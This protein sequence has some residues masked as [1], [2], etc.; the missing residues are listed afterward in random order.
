[1]SILLE[2]NEAAMQALYLFL[3]FLPLAGF[4]AE[5]GGK[6]YMYEIRIERHKAVPM[7]DSVTLYADVYRP[8]S[9]GRYPTLLVRTPYGLQRDGVHETMIK[10]A[11]RGYSVVVVDNRGRYESG[12]NWDPF[13]SE[14][15]DGYDAI[16]WAAKQNFSNGKVATQGGSYLG[17]VQ[18]A[19]ASQQPPSLVAMFPALAST[20]I[21]ANWITHGGAFRLSFNYGW[22]VVRMPNRIML[23]Q[24]W[25]TEAYTP[26]ELKYENI[27]WHLPLNTGDLKSAGSEVKHYRDWLAHPS[28]DSYWKAISDEER[29]NKMQVPAEVSGG[30]FDIFLAGTINGYTMMK[31]QAATERARKNTRMIIGPWGHGPTQKYGDVDF[32]KDAMINQ[33]DEELAFFDHNLKGLDNGLDRNLPVKIFYMGVNKWRS[34]KD[35]PIPDTN[36]RELYLG[37]AGAANSV[38]GGGTLSF[39]KPAATQIHQYNYNPEEPVLTMGGN[40]C[41][42]TPTPAGPKDQRHIEGRNDVLVYTSEFLKTPISIAGPVKMKLTAATDGPDTDWMVKLVDVYPNGF[43]MPVAEGILRARFRN[44]LDKP[45]LLTPNTVYDFTVDLVGTA[46][47]FQPGHRIRVD[48]TSSNFPQFDRN[49]NTGEALGAGTRTRVAR[50]SVHTGGPRPSHIVLPVVTQP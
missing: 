3:L 24:Y 13:R 1:M 43:A 41:C 46:N 6:P 29:M 22:G 32:G 34:E 23:P 4:A 25:H 28:Y 47:V 21:Y 16:E 7:R 15:Q 48:I 2:S 42:G 38:R 11:Q 17:H 39:D 5:P 27:L 33:F 26:E 30:W 19:A 31:Q 20:N 36:Y 14:A 8:S 12:G 10:F 18:W 50:Q 40:N 49:P 37:G 45:E 44:G 9:E 35:W